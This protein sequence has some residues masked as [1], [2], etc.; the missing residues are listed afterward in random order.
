MHGGTFLGWFFAKEPGSFLGD[1]ITLVQTLQ[2]QGTYRVAF[3]TRL[4]RD[5]STQCCAGAALS[6]LLQH[7]PVMM[8]TH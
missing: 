7:K 6:A 5:Q 3:I 4:L 2:R 8:V 1:E